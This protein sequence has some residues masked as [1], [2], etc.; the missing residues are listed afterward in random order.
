MTPDQFA[1]VERLFEEACN[2][3]AAHRLEWLRGRCTDDPDVL[4]KVERMLAHDAR[5]LNA[6]DAPAL[7]GGFH[8]A[9]VD[10][11]ERF[12][13]EEFAAAG[14]FRID[15]LLGEGGFGA[16]YRATQLR[17][18]CREVALKVIK[19]GM[20]TRRVLARFE[21][22][23]QTLAIM[24]HPGIARLI[25]AGVTASGRSYFVMDLVEGRPITAYCREA[26][27]EIR[28][29][30]RL[31]IDLCNAV[32]HAHQRGVLH[33][34]IKPSNVLVATRDGRPTPVVID[35]GIARALH[36]DD[37]PAASLVTEQG[38]LIGTPE[39]MSPEQSAGERDIDTR[40]DVY[41]LGV[42]LYE[43]LTGTTPFERTAIGAAGVAELQRM[44]REQEPP[45]PSTRV[46]SAMRLNRTA[47][48]P[49]AG[50]AAALAGALRGDLDWIVMKALEKDR[51]RRYDSSD[52]LAADLA[53]YLN[54][55]PVLARPQSAAHRFA[56]FARRHR[57]AL[58]AAA[59][60][61]LLLIAGVI[62]TGIGLV[63]ARREAGIARRESQV[64]QS[65]T[66]FLNDDLLAAVAP[67]RLGND[68][69]MRTVVE[70]AARRLEGKFADQ[71]LVEA[72]VRL[73]LGRTFS[74]LS[75]LAAAE[76]HLL[77][78]MELRRA[79][80]GAEALPTLEA[81][82]ELSL[83]FKMQD[84]NG[85]A[86][87]LLRQVYEARRRQLGEPHADSISSLYELSVAIGEQGRLDETETLMMQ[88]LELARRRLGTQ[89]ALTLTILR[90][91]G[92]LHVT[93]GQSDEAAL[94]FEEAHHQSLAALGAE[95]P[96][97]LLATQDWASSCTRSGRFAEA[98]SLLT[99]ALAVSTRLRG[100]SHP[101]TLTTMANLANARHRLRRPQEAE[102][103]FRS[104][105]DLARRDL[106]EG[107]S[108]IG[109][110]Q[111]AFAAFYEAE[112][113][114]DLAEPLQLECYD[115]LA[116]TLGSQHPLTLK[117]IRA[118]IT[119]YETRGDAQRAAT[120]AERLR[121]AESAS[122][123]GP[124]TR[125]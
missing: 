101:A 39:Y 35:F 73:S 79:T 25:D 104:A 43:L 112:K 1:R 15:A 8:V 23:R 65:V 14:R 72:A 13:R 24:N 86:E 47:A 121:A 29:R 58:A 75:D 59:T 113:R 107:N 34:D 122:A 60:I 27:L 7:G 32:R 82:H 78:A 95:N 63:R 90:G 61:A 85:E 68:V 5:R 92:V 105:L 21:A 3:P 67:D 42:L 96:I 69:S 118:L 51:A 80:L 108:V 88:A 40:T 102:A 66:D 93:R 109:R 9:H 19:F 36:D 4:R 6:L 53:R 74:K 10:D 30:L 114:F 54:D 83:V 17:P 28:T 52:A 62:G 50:N 64:A 55:E 116:K 98:E 48:L 91:V 45:T 125:G 26:A 22:E 123:P 44:I 11:A 115:S 111:S 46:R 120:W 119:H 20:D 124:D 110:L 106:P 81:G 41:S 16:V 89:H 84:R 103:L 31:F 2:R 117:A 38:Q 71:P 56:K 12:L 49:A 100:E 57:G 76:R 99:G 33:R 87:K 77:R 94:Y 37:G 70:A 18:V 97:S